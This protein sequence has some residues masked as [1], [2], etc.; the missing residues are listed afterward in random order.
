MNR[1]VSFGKAP[2]D[3][4]QGAFSKAL[5]DKSI[6]VYIVPACTKYHPTLREA[7]EMLGDKMW[8]YE[9]NFGMVF[10]LKLRAKRYVEIYPN[11]ELYE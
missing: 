1:V 8:I 4:L 5:E 6:L 10:N 9:M 2:F 3:N 7:K 11:C